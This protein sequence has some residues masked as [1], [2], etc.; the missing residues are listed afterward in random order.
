M[1]KGGLM[2]ILKRINRTSWFMPTEA[3]CSRCFEIEW[4]LLLVENSLAVQNPG[5]VVQ[6][7]NCGLTKK[8]RPC[9]TFAS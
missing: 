9:L 5:I 4:E 3:R 1:K 2:E 7:G 8:M 6:C